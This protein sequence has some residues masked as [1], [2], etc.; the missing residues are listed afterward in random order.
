MKTQKSQTLISEMRS[1][2]ST[3]ATFQSA[4]TKTFCDASSNSKTDSP[5]T[6]EVFARNVQRHAVEFSELCSPIGNL[7]NDQHTA[8]RNRPPSWLSWA[9]KLK[10]SRTLPS[11]AP[12][13]AEPSEPK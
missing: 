5:E 11:A 2:S 10:L 8:G 1:L 12:P 6:S 7:A 13:S 4:P 9:T 3:L